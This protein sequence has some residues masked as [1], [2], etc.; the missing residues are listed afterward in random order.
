MKQ[1]EYSGTCPRTEQDYLRRQTLT[2]LFLSVCVCA[3]VILHVIC[4]YADAPWVW[5][6]NEPLNNRKQYDI[7]SF[8]DPTLLLGLGAGNETRHGM[9]TQDVCAWN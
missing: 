1:S 2:D 5:Q 4:V 7:V 3:S 8:P 9:G 6:I